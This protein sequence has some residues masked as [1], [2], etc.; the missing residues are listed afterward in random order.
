M[1]LWILGVDIM[2]CHLVLLRITLRLANYPGS[3]SAK[4]SGD[5]VHVYDMSHV[6]SGNG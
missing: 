1:P 6:P 4:G 2:L 5:G 3:G